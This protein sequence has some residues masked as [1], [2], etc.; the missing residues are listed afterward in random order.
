MLRCLLVLVFFTLVNAG[1]AAEV[2]EPVW[3]GF[4]LEEVADAPPLRVAQVATGATADR[5]GVKPGDRLVSVGTTPVTTTAEVSAAMVPLTVGAPIKL[6][7]RRDGAE[8]ALSGTI[9]AVPR[10]RQL[11]TDA[12]RLR[13]DI[14][15][16]KDDGERARLTSD[17]QDCLRVLAKLQEGLPKMAGDF[18]RLYPTG[19]FS[20]QIHIDVRSAP[21]EPVQVPLA[22]SPAS[23]SEKP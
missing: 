4:D 9:A 7:V 17:L 5:M 22:P 10:P 6:T 23:P 2:S 21:T 14:A 12:D 3:L 18:K 13:S 16:L 8:L 11:L 15:K 20:V 19:T 1:E